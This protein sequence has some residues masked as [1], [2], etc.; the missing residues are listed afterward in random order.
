MSSDA[1]IG[2]GR[3]KA[4]VKFISYEPVMESCYMEP[5]FLQDAGINWIVIGGWDR[6]KT[7]PSNLLDK[8]DRWQ[9]EPGIPVF[10]K[11]NLKPLVFPGQVMG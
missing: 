7:Q 8:R 2:L 3:I 6:G 11:D 1:Y 10:L 9:T 4:K 5:Q